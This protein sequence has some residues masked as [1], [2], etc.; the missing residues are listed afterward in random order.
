M[1]LYASD[2]TIVSDQLIGFLCPR[3]LALLDRIYEGMYASEA[4]IRE[5]K[6]LGRGRERVR[7]LT[8]RF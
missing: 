5:L 6:I 8:T 4:E 1:E 2:E 3:I 7:D